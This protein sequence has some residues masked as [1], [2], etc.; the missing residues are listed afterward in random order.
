MTEFITADEVANKIG[1]ASGKA[2]LRRRQAL[3][4]YGRF[5]K[6]MPTCLRPMKWRCQDV[7]CWLKEQSVATVSRQSGAPLRLV[8]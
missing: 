3:E 5:P 8:G 7:D 1:F 2:F 6:P 4:N